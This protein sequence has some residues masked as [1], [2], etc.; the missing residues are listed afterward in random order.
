MLLITLSSLLLIGSLDMT[1]NEPET[2]RFGTIQ[3]S[4]AICSPADRSADCI[5]KDTRMGLSFDTVYLYDFGSELRLVY[6]EQHCWTRFFLDSY[7]EISSKKKLAKTLHLYTQ[8]GAAS[9]GRPRD[10]AEIDAQNSR[11]DDNIDD[12]FAATQFMRKR[13]KAL[14]GLSEARCS[15]KPDQMP[16]CHKDPYL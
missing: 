3:Y 1:T 11:I 13:A 7:N 6:K 10:P 4:E 2:R 15:S 12:L 9:C 16:A 5:K 14:F 8:K